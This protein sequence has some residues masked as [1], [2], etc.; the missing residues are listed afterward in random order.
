MGIDPGQ[1]ELKDN[2]KYKRIEFAWQHSARS[3]K[4]LPGLLIQKDAKTVKIEVL[5]KTIKSEHNGIISYKTAYITDPKQIKQFKKRK[6]KKEVREAKRKGGPAKKKRPTS[7]SQQDYEES[8][9]IAEPGKMI[10]KIAKPS[11]LESEYDE[12]NEKYQETPNKG[13]SLTI[14]LNLGDIPHAAKNMDF[15]VPDVV[16]KQKPSGSRKRQN[17]PER[18]Y[19]E[20]LEDIVERCLDLDK[21]WFFHAPVTKREAP[22]YHQI[23]V[24]PMDLGTMKNKIRRSE[25]KN[26]DDFKKDLALIR[27]NAEKFNGTLSPISEEARNIENKGLELLQKY[28]AS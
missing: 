16:A 21:K 18:Q 24:N 6:S 25:Y 20:I 1:V 15:E 23:I 19:N 7:P 17:D 5:K 12:E 22:T 14:K 8:E 2:K 11:Q 4:E 26:L 3:L 10:I 27:S 9:S 13:E 28:F